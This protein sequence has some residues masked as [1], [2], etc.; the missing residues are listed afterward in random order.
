MILSLRRIRTVAEEGIV[1]ARRRIQETLHALS[2]RGSQT[3]NRF[4]HP[5]DPASVWRDPAITALH[6]PDTGDADREDDATTLRI[7]AWLDGKSEGG[8]CRG[9]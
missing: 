9:F 5:V 6:R 4:D 7:A 2:K 8:L 1:R 3:A